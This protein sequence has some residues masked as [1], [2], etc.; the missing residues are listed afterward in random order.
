MEKPR[1]SLGFLRSRAAPVCGAGGRG[2]SCGTTVGLFAASDASR[3]VQISR[4]TRS[5]A[6]RRNDSSVSVSLPRAAAL[7][8]A[9]TAL[10][11]AVKSKA[12]P[13]Q[14]KQSG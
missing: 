1:K 6:P 7:E 13:A 12:D 2:T 3:G 4:T 11:A 8:K 10:G 5:A 14:V 9:L